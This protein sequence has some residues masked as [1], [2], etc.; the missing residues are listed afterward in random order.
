M[1]GYQ[2]RKA[3][4]SLIIEKERG[5]STFFSADHN[6]RL[7]K[8]YPTIYLVLRTLELSGPQGMAPL[9]DSSEH[10][11]PIPF[12]AAAPTQNVFKCPLAHYSYTINKYN[13]PS[14]F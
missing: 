13:M 14:Q 2:R 1:L 12:R 8:Y 7:D 11:F 9:W 4:A 10:Q 6:L 5:Q 3:G